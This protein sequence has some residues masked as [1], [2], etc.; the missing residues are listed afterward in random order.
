M[1]QPCPAEQGHTESFSEEEAANGPDPQP[2][3]EGLQE[4]S[5][6]KGLDIDL[7]PGASVLAPQPP[8]ET[9]LPISSAPITRALGIEIGT[10]WENTSS[11]GFIDQYS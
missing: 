7:Q 8:V 10:N 2:V 11:F 9:S 6:S 5:V 1:D 4:E 3:A